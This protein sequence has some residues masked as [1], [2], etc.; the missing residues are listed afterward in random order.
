MFNSHFINVE[1]LAFL[2]TVIY[3]MRRISTVLRLDESGSRRMGRHCF[4][5]WCY[6]FIT[7]GG[8]TIYIL[9][10]ILDTRWQHRYYIPSSP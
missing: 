5:C 2:N 6:L 8:S 10:P 7:L 1:L 3:Q 9:V 4:G